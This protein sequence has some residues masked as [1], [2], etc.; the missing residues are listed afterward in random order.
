M[1]DLQQLLCILNIGIVS[2]FQYQL[3]IHAF[4][5]INISEIRNTHA[6]LKLS[7]SSSLQSC[8]AD[9]FLNLDFFFLFLNTKPQFVQAQ[10]ICK[11]D[12]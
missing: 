8:Q 6:I 3:E 1:S 11:S 10:R 12:R 4:F 5:G 7:P 9:L 2:T